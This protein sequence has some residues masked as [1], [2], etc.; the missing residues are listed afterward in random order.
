MRV[1]LDNFLRD[2][3]TGEVHPIDFRLMLILHQISQETQSSGVYEVISAYRSKTTNKEL[4]R[5]S[6][7]VAQKSLHVLGQAIDVRLTDVPTRVLRDAA[8]DLKLGGVGYYAKADF[9]HIDTGD[10]RTW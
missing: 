10:F 7:G 3:R 2:H 6:R 8:A 9:V 5:K 1:G 4:R